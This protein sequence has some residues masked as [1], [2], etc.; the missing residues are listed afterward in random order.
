MIEKSFILL[1][2]LILGVGMFVFGM[3]GLL[4]GLLWLIEFLAAAS[5]WAN[6]GLWPTFSVLQFIQKYGV[7]APH[8]DM[9][10]L[11][12]I[13][14]GCLAQSSVL[15]VFLFVVA[16]GWIST[17]LGDVMIPMTSKKK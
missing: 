4:I 14:D 16:C 9:V 8:T 10:G 11:Q 6:T 15:V 3:L 12:N 7:N 17:I 1:L 5:A 13:L 2:N